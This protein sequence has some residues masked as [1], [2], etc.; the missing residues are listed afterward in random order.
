MEMVAAVGRPDRAKGEMPIAYV[1]LA[2][3][4]A[5]EPAELLA[6]CR[7]AVQEKAAVPVNVVILDRLPLTP[8]GKIAKPALRSLALKDEV[9]QVV[10]SCSRAP[11]DCVIDIDEAGLRREVTVSLGADAAS[12]VDI[13]SLTDQ[14]SA[15]EFL[16]R[17][18]VGTLVSTP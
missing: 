6:F 15:Y 17:I 2:A 10:S 7:T 3:G 12:N 9:R 13:E 16:A 4:S 11:V 14:L 5:V 1:E 8:V 18:E